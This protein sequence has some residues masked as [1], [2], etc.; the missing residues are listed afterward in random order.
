MWS[1]TKQWMILMI[2]HPIDFSMVMLIF[3]Q[4]SSILHL[5]LIILTSLC[6]NLWICQTDMYF[7]P[8]DFHPFG[9]EVKT[10]THKPVG[11]TLWNTQH[12]YY[13]SYHVSIS[14]HPVFLLSDI[15]TTVLH[16]CSWNDFPLYLVSLT[17]PN[18]Q[19][20]FDDCPAPM[21]ICLHVLCCL[22]ALQSLLVIGNCIHQ[23]FIYIST[24]Q[25]MIP[26]DQ[27]H[28][29]VK[30]LQLLDDWWKM[31]FTQASLMPSL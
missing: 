30:C 3:L 31:Y 23:G 28:F 19:S 21:H 24:Y 16:L 29:V 6:C 13:G 15:D 9:V 7:D 26:I 14:D 27:V 2:N 17:A 25:V 18:C 22:S 4:M 12:L 10:F 8:L 11:Y 5:A 20:S 1:L